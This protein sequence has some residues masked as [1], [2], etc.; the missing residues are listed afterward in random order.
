MTKHQE[1]RQYL[2]SYGHF[3]FLVADGDEFMPS[4]DE[5]F[6]DQFDHI[7]DSRGSYHQRVVA[8]ALHV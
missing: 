5:C 1:E 3:F 4:N 8:I 6:V 2:L 7:N